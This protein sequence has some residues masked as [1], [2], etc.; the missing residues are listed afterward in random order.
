MRTYEFKRGH[1]KNVDEVETIMK[2]IFGNVKR[3]GDHLISE[4]GG[5]EKIEVWIEKNRLAVETK[6]RQV[7]EQEAIDTIKVWNDFLFRVTGYTAKERK[8]KLT[9][10]K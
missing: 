5:L 9:G 1:R 6:T 7:A 10:R 2:E 8:K 3:Y 4:Y